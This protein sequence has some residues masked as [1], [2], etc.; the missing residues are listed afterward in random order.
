VFR[1]KLQPEDSPKPAADLRSVASGLL[2]RNDFH[3]P[4][5]EAVKQSGSKVNTS[6][7][8]RHTHDAA[9]S[10]ADNHSDRDDAADDGP[11]VTCSACQ[12]HR[13]VLIFSLIYCRNVS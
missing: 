2:S 9:D 7:K 12:S 6:A 13:L 10:I 5:E 11:P 4:V 1:S 3:K 8:A